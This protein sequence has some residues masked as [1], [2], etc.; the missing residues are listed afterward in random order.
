MLRSHQ[1][2]I[3]MREELRQRIQ[4]ARERL[5][6]RTPTEEERAASKRR[7][8]MEEFKM[9]LVGKTDL[10]VRAELLIGADYFWLETEPAVR[11]QVDDH[12]FALAKQ[13]GECRLLEETGRQ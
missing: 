10:W 9:F 7:E 5:G 3:A 13:E 2:G 6:M 11:F 8:V 1:E 12:V 4:E